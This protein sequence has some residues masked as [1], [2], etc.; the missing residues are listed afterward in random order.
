MNVKACKNC[1]LVVY[2]EKTCPKCGGELGEKVL[3]LIIIIDPERSEIAKVAGITSFGTYAI[4][5][6]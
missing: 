3:G 5:V 2:T 1:R 4:H 6:S